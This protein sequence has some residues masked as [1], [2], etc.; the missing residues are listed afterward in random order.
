VPAIPN[1]DERLSDGTVAIRYT[2]GRD[3]PEILIAY[4]DD[5]SLHELLGEDQPPSGAELGRQAERGELDRSVGRSAELTIVEPPN[6]H[7]VGQ[8]RVRRI[9]WSHGRADLEIWLAPQ[10]RGRGLGA[11]A[12]RLVAPW[13][14]G[15][16]GLERVQ[17]L[18]DPDN[19]AVRRAARA[20]GFTEEGMLR[21]YARQR[22]GGRRD[23]A[24]LSLLPHD[25]SPAR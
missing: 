16:C 1:L 19:A 22:S 4:E 3:I 21:A 14:F 24:V 20:A 7:C 8:V 13:L 23:C 17:I 10:A 25:V 6:D 9:E 2:A 11:G 5:P 18:A 15:S 12:L